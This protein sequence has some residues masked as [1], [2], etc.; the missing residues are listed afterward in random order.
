MRFSKKLIVANQE[1][2]ANIT[3]RMGQLFIKLKTIAK[4]FAVKWKE[5]EKLISSN[6]ELIQILE[7]K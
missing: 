2:N 3:D 4:D 7:T 1:I 6:Q 5:N